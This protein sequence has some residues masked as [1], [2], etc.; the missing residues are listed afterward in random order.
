MEKSVMPCG[1]SPQE[2]GYIDALGADCRYIVPIVSNPDLPGVGSLL[3][4]Q[5]THA[6]KS[7]ASRTPFGRAVCLQNGRRATAGGAELKYWSGDP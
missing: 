3:R 7:R 4:V 1:A 2:W 5:K 6:A